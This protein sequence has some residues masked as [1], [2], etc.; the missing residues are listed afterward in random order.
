MGYHYGPSADLLVLVCVSALLFGITHTRMR[1]S[2][3][4]FCRDPLCRGA[5]CDPKGSMALLQN[6]FR[7]PPMLGAQRTKGQV[8]C[9]VIQ[10]EERHFAEQVPVSAY[11]VSSKNHKKVLRKGEV[12]AYVRRKRNL[13]DLKDRKET[14]LFCGCFLM[15]REVLA[16]VGRNGILKDRKDP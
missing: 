5:W 6:N 13:K 1:I 3:N 7:C 16:Y 8:A 11:I 12:L 2:F 9:D 10:E 15:K 14:G 4:R